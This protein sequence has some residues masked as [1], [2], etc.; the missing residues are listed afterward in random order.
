MVQVTLE[1]KVQ[2]TIERKT[3]TEAEKG[4]CLQRK[5]RGRY[6]YRKRRKEGSDSEKE[7]RKVQIEEG[8]K[9]VSETEAEKRRCI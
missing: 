8:V 6:G 9:E 3:N 5:N 7:E 1:R 4:R 2:V